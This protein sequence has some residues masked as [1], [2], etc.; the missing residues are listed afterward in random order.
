MTISKKITPTIDQGQSP[1]D[2]VVIN[3]IS[4]NQTKIAGRIEIGKLVFTPNKQSFELQAIFKAIE[5]GL[6][7]SWYLSLSSRTHNNYFFILK[8]FLPWINTYLFNP[9]N[10]FNALKL[11]LIHI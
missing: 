5:I 1:F 2:N 11:S 6:T 7:S 3:E 4:Q 10:R 8:K 9:E